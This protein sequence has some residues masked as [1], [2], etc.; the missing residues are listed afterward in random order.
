MQMELERFASDTAGQ[1]ETTVANE[2]ADDDLATPIEDVPS[3]SSD[4][5]R[6][7]N[8]GGWEKHTRV[9]ETNV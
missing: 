7:G 9:C 1:G 2:D 4:Q 6:L 8:L 3:S 5:P